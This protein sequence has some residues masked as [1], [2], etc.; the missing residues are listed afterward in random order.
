MT[1]SVYRIVVPK[2]TE[3]VND[4]MLHSLPNFPILSMNMMTRPHSSGAFITLF[5]CSPLLLSLSLSELVHLY[6]ISPSSV[7]PYTSITCMYVYIHAWYDP[8]LTWVRMLYSWL[9]CVV[10]RVIDTFFPGLMYYY[11]CCITHTYILVYLDESTAVLLYLSAFLSWPYILIC[12]HLSYPWYH[13][14]TCDLLIFHGWI[15]SSYRRTVK[16]DIAKYVLHDTYILLHSCTFLEN[17]NL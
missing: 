10:H 13:R 5:S 12:L 7:Q 9:L 2:C 1:D 15:I 4:W 3:H 16:H 6:C 14:H 8:D 17:T 11:N